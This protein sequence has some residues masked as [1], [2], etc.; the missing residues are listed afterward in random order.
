MTVQGLTGRERVGSFLALNKRLAPSIMLDAIKKL[1]ILQDRDR[2]LLK[3]QDELAH[4]GPER[5]QLQSRLSGVQGDYESAKTKVR[6][7]E[8]EKKRLELDVDA[9]KQLIE[10]Y[11]LQ[12]FQ[13]KRNEEYRALAHELTRAKRPS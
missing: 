1:L 11:S 13:T 6:Q 5:T 7:I 4:I 9:K 2:Q 12:Q 10:K 8:S 3:V